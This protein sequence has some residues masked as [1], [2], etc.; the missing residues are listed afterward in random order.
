MLPK[1]SEVRDAPVGAM[2]DAYWFRGEKHESGLA[3]DRN[4]DGLVLVVMTP[5][6]TW[7]I[8]GPSFVNRNESGNWSRTGI[9]PNITVTP[10]IHIPGKYHGRL[11]AGELVECLPA[12][13]TA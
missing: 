13:A 4:P 10:S 5:G 7:M 9:A 11:I 1:K 3:Y 12:P 6:G 2:W 8:D